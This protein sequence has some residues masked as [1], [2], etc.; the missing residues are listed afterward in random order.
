[1]HDMHLPL[2]V[3]GNLHNLR[4]ALLRMTEIA[5]LASVL[6]FRQIEIAP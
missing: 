3:K 5:H 6:L 1:M 4:Q 2:T